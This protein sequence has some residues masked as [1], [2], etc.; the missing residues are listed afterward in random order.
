M[1]TSL[2]PPYPW[3]GGKRQVCG[4]VW[5]RLGDLPRYVEPFL[6]G[7][8]MLLGRPDAHRH[9][10]HQG[11][12]ELVNDANGFV[13]NFWRAI[14][15]D[16]GAVAS[17]LAGPIA[18]LDLHARGGWL[19][20]RRAHV[21]QCRHDPH[22]YDA[23]VAAWWA[24][25]QTWAIGCDWNRLLAGRPIRSRPQANSGQGIT[26]AAVGGMLA[27]LAER[28]AHLHVLCGDWR[29]ACTR[30]V[31]WYSDRKPRPTAIFL[32]P[33]YGDVGRDT[34][35]YG[36]H[37]S[38]SIAADVRAWCAEHGARP[39]LRIALCGY[40]GEHNELETLGW[41]KWRWTAA[42]GYGNA[43][44]TTNRHRE[45][46]WFSPHCLAGAQLRRAA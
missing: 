31:T 8:A 35:L 23:R 28:V 9:G 36:V 19:H 41:R 24:W 30:A 42:G 10:S 3:F 22:W 39:Y 45:R 32:D 40:E 37:D 21:E 14:R 46:I 38:T 29:R 4:P 2:R 34:E 16:A 11:G 44:R 1:T 20:E 33:P 13:V 27:R 17:H 5:Q 26:A 7:G 6:G 18:E 43:S 12:Y 15:A 25:G